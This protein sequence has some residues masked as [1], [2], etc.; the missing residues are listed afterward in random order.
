MHRKGN[1]WLEREAHREEKRD[2]RT[3]GK[4]NT[5]AWK[6]KV[7]RKWNVKYFL[8]CNKISP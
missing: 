2:A 3:E 1:K 8:V 7:C 5:S 4:G 6:I